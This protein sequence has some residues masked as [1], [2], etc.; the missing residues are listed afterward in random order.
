MRSAGSEETKNW[1]LFW[2]AVHVKS[3]HEFK[4]ADRL[5]DAGIEA[6]LPVVERQSRWKDRK[7]VV[8]FPLF[9]GYLFVRIEKNNEAKMVVLKTSGVVRFVGFKPGD[10]EN[11]PDEQIDSLKKLVENKASLDPYPYLKE[12][13]R[14]RIKRGPLKGV[15]GIIVQRH[16]QHMIVLSVDVL[17]QGAAL[18]IDT[19]QVE[20]V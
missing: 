20:N 4:V 2:Y 18:K 1:D 11:V 14:V 19:S 5:S 15:E 17:Q 9:P 3:R 12:G 8:T 7:K 13:R 10:P 6:F 16:G